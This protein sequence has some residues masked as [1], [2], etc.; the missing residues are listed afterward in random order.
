[1]GHGAA[2]DR[3][4][5]ELVAMPG[6]PPGVIVL[7]QRGRHVTVHAAGAAKV[8]AGSLPRATDHMRIASV[9]KVFSG[10]VALA[11]VAKRRLSPEDTIGELL[12]DLPLSWHQASSRQL[13]NH[14]S[15]LPDFTASTEFVEAVIASP[16]SPPPPRALLEFVADQPLGFAPGSQFRYSNSDNI[17]VALMIEAVTGKTY[18]QALRR[19]ALRPLRPRDTGLPSGVELPDP[20]IHGYVLAD[21]GKPEDVSEVVAFGG[22]A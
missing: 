15:G 9:S 2:L 8:G 11:L 5:D 20:F 10:A 12:P 17:A 1:L 19:Q 13:L 18:A 16:T 7:I 4:L 14:T 6:G 22:W 3:A 21:P